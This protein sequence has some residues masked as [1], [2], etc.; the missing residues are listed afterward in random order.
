MDLNSSRIICFNLSDAGRF[1]SSISTG[2]SFKSDTIA[3]FTTSSI[4]LSHSGCK[5]ISRYLF[6]RSCSFL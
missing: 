5:A 1:E 3:S 4:A 6:T 2:E